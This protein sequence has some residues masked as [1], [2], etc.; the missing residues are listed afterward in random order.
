MHAHLRPLRTSSVLYL[1]D[2]A[3]TWTTTATSTRESGDRALGRPHPLEIRR[4]C[5]PSLPACILETWPSPLNYEEL[6]IGARDTRILPKSWR[7][8]LVAK[9][10]TKATYCFAW[11]TGM[12]YESRPGCSIICGNFHRSTGY[13]DMSLLSLMLS[14]RHWVEGRNSIV[15]N[16]AGRRHIRDGHNICSHQRWRYPPK[17][18]IPAKP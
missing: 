11:T 10:A 7:A 16:T 1:H 5:F 15:Y 2:Q 9:M 17:A 6:A 14:F 12:L 4:Y 8:T 3:S 13:D 18:H